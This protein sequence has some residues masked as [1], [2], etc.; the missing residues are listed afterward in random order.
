MQLFKPHA[1]LILII[2]IASTRRTS[3]HCLGIFKTGNVFYS[4]LPPNIV[5]P[6][7]SIISSLSLSFPGKL[8]VHRVA[9][10]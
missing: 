2:C 7:I 1:K 8:Y 6:A 5:S 4:P 10:A 9:V 3:E